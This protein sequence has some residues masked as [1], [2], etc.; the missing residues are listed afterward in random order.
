MQVFV[1]RKVS[2]TKAEAVTYSRPSH[3][4]TRSEKSSSNAQTNAADVC[5]L[6]ELPVFQK[7]VRTRVGFVKF[8]FIFSCDGDTNENPRYESV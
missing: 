8:V 7:L 6:S 3:V 2:E 4:E 1:T 5:G